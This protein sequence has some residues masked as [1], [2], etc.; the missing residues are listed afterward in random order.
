MQL[1]SMGDFCV[2]PLT[3]GMAT[4]VDPED[5]DRV[6]KHSWC[7]HWHPK[8]KSHT[9]VT[10]LVENGKPRL[11]YMHRVICGMP[12]GMCVD[13]INHNTLDNRKEN[14]RVCTHK[15]NLRNVKISTRNTSGYKGVS[16]CKGRKRWYA[17]IGI[18]G[19]TIP[20]GRYHTAKEAAMAYDEAAIKHF[21]EFARTNILEE[22]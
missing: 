10:N 16:W 12:V 1:K 17:Y 4:I 2:I 6:A 11:E 22:K 8:A 5:Y 18:N 14:L 3:Q 15:E 9:A 19:K 13:H 7:A 20:L 21:G